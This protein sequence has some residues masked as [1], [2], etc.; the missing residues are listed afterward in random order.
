MHDVVA[1][2]V[3]AHGLESAG[4]DMQGD[5]AVLHAPA[6]QNPKQRLVE[7]Q[8]RRG[9]R[10]GA[11]SRRIHGLIALTIVFIVFSLDIRRQRHT[12]DAG[13]QGA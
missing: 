6:I 13:Q 7:V 2:V 5:V 1:D 3:R 12:P 10:N 8:A 11:V 9:R 4:A